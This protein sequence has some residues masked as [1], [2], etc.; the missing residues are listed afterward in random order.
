MPE[1][2]HNFTKGK[3]NKD[4][5]E[6]LVP[7]GEYRDA[8]NIQVATSEGSDVGTVQNV[9]GNKEVT[10]LIPVLVGEPTATFTMPPNANVVG[11]ISDEKID[12]MYYLVWSNTVDWILSWKR[13]DV[14]PEFVFIDMDKEVLKLPRNKIIT[15]I[16]VIDGMLFWTDG[17]NEPRKINIQRCKDGTKTISQTRLIN[18]A[19]G[20]DYN[21]NVDLEE[22]HITVIKKG[23]QVAPDMKLHTVRD[24][25]KNYTAVMTISSV[26]DVNG[27]LNSFTY[28]SA[29]NGIHDFSSLSTQE[30][31]NK[32]WVKLSTSYF[33][34][35]LD[36]A[37]T[38]LTYLDPLDALEG[39]TGW[40]DVTSLIGL[41]VALQVYGEDNV[42]PGL[43]LTDFVIK[44]EI[45]AAPTT[46]PGAG[47]LGIQATTVDGFPPQTELGEPTRRYVIDLFEEEEKLFEFKFPRFSYRYKFEDGEYSTFAP[48]TQVAFTPGSFDYHPRKG[49]NK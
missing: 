29:S 38:E 22:R 15:G 17:V 45:F 49:Y 3:M 43:P 21:S 2:K 27:D 48:F 33:G 31:S 8:M 46:G 40:G 30:G 35:V 4:L 39:L 42:P 44:G 1:I 6:R 26:A 10:V 14:S 47:T 19:A 16:N 11:S 7:N 36:G 20:I 13:G 12:T 41:K 23:P 34:A 24:L 28:D 32:F 9:L 18:T 37:N 5:D 25:D